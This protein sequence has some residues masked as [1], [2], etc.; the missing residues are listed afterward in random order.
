MG[1]TS[2]QVSMVIGMNVIRSCYKQLLRQ[3]GCIHL[4]FSIQGAR[5]FDANTLLQKLEKE[6]AIHR[7]QYYHLYPGEA[8]P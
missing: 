5:S 8:I 4:I 2:L 7:S 6:Q 1:G 3:Y